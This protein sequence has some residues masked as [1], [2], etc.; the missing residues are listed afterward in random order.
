MIFSRS[1]NGIDHRALT[2]DAREHVTNRASLLYQLMHIGDNR[3]KL[4]KEFVQSIDD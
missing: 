2:L 4:P 3:G 1:W